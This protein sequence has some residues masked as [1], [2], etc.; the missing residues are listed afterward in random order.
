MNSTY[1]V[2]FVPDSKGMLG[3]LY[4]MEG[5]D[6]HSQKD[7]EVCAIEALSLNSSELRAAD[8]KLREVFPPELEAAARCRSTRG[9][10]IRKA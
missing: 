7:A 6:V 8:F 4:D 1:C 5:R 10:E 2:E 9:A 3:I